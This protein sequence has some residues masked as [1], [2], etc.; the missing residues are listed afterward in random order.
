MA[1]QDWLL[2]LLKG[3]MIGDHS[4]VRRYEPVKLDQVPIVGIDL[5]ILPSAQDAN[6]NFKM[7]GDLS[8]GGKDIGGD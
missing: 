5:E 4:S 2:S 1:D 3:R 8:E 6:G 7:L